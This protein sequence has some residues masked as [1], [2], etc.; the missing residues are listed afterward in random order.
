MKKIVL[1]I[2]LLLASSLVQA[3]QP[4]QPPVKFVQQQEQAWLGYFN[5]TRFSNHW[6]IWVD[7]HH[8]RTDFL[9][10]LNL[11]LVRAG[12]TYYVNDNLRLTAGYAYAGSALS[13]SG[14]IRPE[15]RPWQ[16]VWWTG[17]AG[18][19]N[20]LQWVR[21]EQRFNHR[22]QGDQLAD[23]Y[24]FNWRFRYNFMLQI[25]F[26]GETIQ[27]GVP[28]FVLQDEVFVNAG[29]QITYNYFDQN[30][31]FVGVSYPFSKSLT[32]Q[33]GYMNQFVQQPAGSSFVSNRTLRFFVFHTLDFRQQ[34]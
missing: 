13:P 8:R 26:K 12:L 30:R 5:Q 3:Q 17:R 1:L 15:H 14:T 33:L 7:L 11:N 16:Q 31:F 23:G 2:F 22:V 32:A 4:T 10:R 21:A 6:G 27:P 34:P 19:F 28:N 9:D 25:P 18:R 20:L 29:K 24:G